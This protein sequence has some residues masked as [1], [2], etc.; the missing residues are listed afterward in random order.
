MCY[1][2]CKYNHLLSDEYQLRWRTANSTIVIKDN[3]YCWEGFQEDVP[4][5]HDNE[6]TRKISSVDVF[7]LQTFKW[8]RKSTTGI[9]P[10]GCLSYACTNIKENIY[11]FG[12]KCK[13]LHSYLDDL[14]EL[15]TITGNWRQFT[16]STPDNSPMKKRGCGMISFNIDGED[17]LLL[18]GGFGPTPVTKHTHSQYV[19]HPD[20]PND[21][22]TN[23]VHIMCISLLPGIT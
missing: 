14:Y 12:G 4:K 21:S 3:L 5:V 18:V 17:N 7:H 23:E 15:N 1:L 2:S 9:P 6:D 16:S 11:Y 8:E 10:S 19:P 22:I 20:Y 13:P